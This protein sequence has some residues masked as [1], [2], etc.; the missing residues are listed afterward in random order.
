MTWPPPPVPEQ[1]LPALLGALAT[2]LGVPPG[3]PV[4][5]L[6]PG[7][8][9]DKATPPALAA[10]AD[11]LCAAWEAWLAEQA[12]DLPMPRLDHVCRRPG[13]LRVQPGWVEVVMPLDDVDTRIRRLGLD[14]DPGWLPWFGY[15]LRYR[16][17]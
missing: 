16:Y 6:L 7:D 2:R 3:D 1:A 12:P 8:A 13:H 15:A 5:R 4:R 10:R 17:A 14:L 9:S 11:A